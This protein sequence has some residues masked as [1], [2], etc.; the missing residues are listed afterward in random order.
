VI[1][2]TTVTTLTL[3]LKDPCDATVLS[4]SSGMSDMQTKVLEASVQSQSTP[5]V[6]DTVSQAKNPS[7]LGNDFCTTRTYTISTVPIANSSPT[8]TTPTQLPASLLTINSSG[9]VTSATIPLWS[10]LGQHQVT[11]KVAFSAT[12]FATTTFVFLIQDCEVLTLTIA[13]LPVLQQYTV[14]DPTKTFSFLQSHAVQAPA[15][16]YEY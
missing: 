4:F 12:Q 15:C 7:G 5:V 2:F 10:Y 8:S 3:I 9:V 14:T 13:T 16:G 11:V 1:Q 6:T